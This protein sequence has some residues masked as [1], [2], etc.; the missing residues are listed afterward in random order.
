M[1]SIAYYVLRIDDLAILVTGQEIRN[2]QYAI[3]LN[4]FA[5]KSFSYCLIANHITE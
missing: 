4:Y 1:V 3:P 5:Y 2:T